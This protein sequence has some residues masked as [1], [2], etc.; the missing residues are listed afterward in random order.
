MTMAMVKFFP[1][2]KTSNS[3]FEV[4]QDKKRWPRMRLIIHWD[5]LQSPFT[6]FI[7]AWLLITTHLILKRSGLNWKLYVNPVWVISYASMSPLQPSKISLVLFLPLLMDDYYKE[8]K[9]TWPV[10]VLH[11]LGNPSKCLPII[12][13]C[14]LISLLCLVTGHSQNTL[15][16]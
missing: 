13:I 12:I 3:S 2:W 9:K 10:H 7:L 14:V 6:P 4:R 11:G 8:R 16:L 1:N 5:P 15:S